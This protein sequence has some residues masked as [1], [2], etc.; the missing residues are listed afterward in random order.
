MKITIEKK[1]IIQ[2]MD[3]MVG[4]VSSAGAMSG[5]ATP[6]ATYGGIGKDQLKDKYP[7]D[8]DSSV[9]YED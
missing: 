9:K 1:K 6:I 2:E 4:G 3:G 8:D 7:K 5:S